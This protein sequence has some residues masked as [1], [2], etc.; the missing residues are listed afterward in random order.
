ME[1][2]TYL[3]EWKSGRAYLSGRVEEWKSLL[4]WSGRV[5]ELEGEE[6]EEEWKSWKSVIELPRPCGN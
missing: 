4:I 1:E 5:E 6:G 3:E 2:L